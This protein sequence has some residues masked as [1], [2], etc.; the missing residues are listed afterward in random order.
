VVGSAVVAMAALLAAC[1][2]SSS[3]SNQPAGNYQVKVTDASFPGHQVVGQTSLMKIDIRNT[4][5]K[6]VPALTVTMNIEGKEGEGARIPFSVHDPQQ[7]LANGDRPVWVLAAKYPRVDG[8]SAPGGAETSGSKTYSFGEVAPGKSVEVVW[9]LSAVRPGKYTVGYEVDAGLSGEA[10]A[11]TS[12][13]VAPGGSFVTDIST[14]LPE[15]EVNG[16]GE[17]V[18]IERGAKKGKGQAESG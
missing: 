13:G 12:S 18:K 11:K 2:G 14:A 8:S 4:G 10:K 17:I 1:G 16:A 15:T 7:G 9:K 5:K 3:D 6:I